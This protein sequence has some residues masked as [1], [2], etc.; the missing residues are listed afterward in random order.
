V[1]AIVVAAAGVWLA[2]GQ[3]PV[4]SISM[5]ARASSCPWIGSTVPVATRVEEVMAHITKAQELAL[6]NGGSGAGYAGSIPAIPAL[7]IPAINL[8]DGPQGGG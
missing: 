7:C 2:T 3:T 4:A 1:A 6:V 5:S 8:E